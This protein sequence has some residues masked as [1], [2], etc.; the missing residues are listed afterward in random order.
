LAELQQYGLVVQQCIH[1]I[2]LDN[3][4]PSLDD[5]R[6]KNEVYRKI[7]L[8]LEDNLKALIYSHV[9]F[10]CADSCNTGFPRDCLMNG[11]SKEKPEL[12]GGREDV[13]SCTA[14][15]GC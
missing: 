10:T 6:H 14:K 11:H 2:Q 7:V 4:L 13:I 12:D 3:V 8:P 9:S 5:I 1:G 15:T